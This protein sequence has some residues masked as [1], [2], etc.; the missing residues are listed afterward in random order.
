MQSDQAVKYSS[1]PPKK[2]DASELNGRLRI[3]FFSVTFTD[4]TVSAG[5]VIELTKINSNVRVLGGL[6]A[7]SG[8]CGSTAAINVG[9]STSGTSTSGMLSLGTAGM[10][11][12]G[13]TAIGQTIANQYGTK[14]TSEYYVIAGVSGGMSSADGKSLYGH[15]L[16]VQD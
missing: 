10:S 1:M 8:N 9:L 4:D 2:L 14:T 5:T 7:C 15:I 16:Y 3:A 11:A 6:V 13:S 12:A